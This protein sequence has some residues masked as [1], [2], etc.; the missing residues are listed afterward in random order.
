MKKS[1]FVIV[2]ALVVALCVPAVAFAAL[3]PSPS[4][5]AERAACPAYAVQRVAT[6]S[7]EGVGGQSPRGYHH[8]EGHRGVCGGYVDADNDGVCDNC[9]AAASSCPGFV[10]ENGDG[11]CDAYGSGQGCPGYSDADGDGMCDNRGSSRNCPGYT[12]ADDD[13]VC[14][15]YGEGCPR[16]QGQGG[17]NGGRAHHGQGHGC[18]R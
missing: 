4:R 14:D 5:V 2:V 3:M 8:P 11:A 1:T 18:W 12:D 6:Q 13:G 17:Q 15:N 7:E 9:D 16:G 10:D